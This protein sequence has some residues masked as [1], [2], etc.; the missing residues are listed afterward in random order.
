MNSIDHVKP[1][2][3]APTLLAPRGPVVLSRRPLLFFS[4]HLYPFAINLKENTFFKN[5]AYIA[6]SS[7]HN[8]ISI[9]YESWSACSIF[10]RFNRFFFPARSPSAPQGRAL[11]P[12]NVSLCPLCSWRWE[13]V[14]LLE[15]FWLN[16]SFF[17]RRPSC[18]KNQF[19]E[20][21]LRNIFTWRYGSV[22][23]KCFT[24]IIALTCCFVP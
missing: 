23:Q 24:V 11:G 6:N 10:S 14:C 18:H 2:S 12:L 13:S 9:H 16:N 20:N 15:H 3:R 21:S 5:T 7:R 1:L 17:G 4:R 19:L 22:Q 8:E